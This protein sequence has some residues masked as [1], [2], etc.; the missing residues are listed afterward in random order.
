MP[1][2]MHAKDL[3]CK[4]LKKREAHYCSCTYV[5]IRIFQ[6]KINTVKSLALAQKYTLGFFLMRFWN[7]RERGLCTNA[8][9]IQGHLWYWNISIFQSYRHW[10]ENIYY[11]CIQYQYHGCIL[12]FIRK[13]LYWKWTSSIKKK[14]RTK[15]KTELNFKS[16]KLENAIA[17]FRKN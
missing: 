9:N 12:P 17:K 3:F 14:L 4:Y 8:G 7:K 13:V 16:M 11:Y 2:S 5:T 6:V 1:R 15:N 10:Y